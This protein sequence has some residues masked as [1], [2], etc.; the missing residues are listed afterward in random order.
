MH[1][2][3]LAQGVLEVALEAAAGAPVAGIEVR[4]GELQAVVPDAFAFSFTLLADGTA[5]AG[6]RI[7]IEAVA[8]DEL[9]VAGV[10]LADG[11]WLR[12]P[13]GAGTHVEPARAG[14]PGGW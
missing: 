8:G 14:P 11:T 1:E 2:I 6:A 5:A 3:G 7:D 13:P 10:Q 9:M 12:P 4:V